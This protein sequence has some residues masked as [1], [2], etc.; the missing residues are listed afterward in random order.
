MQAIYLD[1]AATTPIHPDVLKV[2]VE[3]MEEHFGNPSSVHSYGRKARQ[4]LDKARMTAAKSIGASDK[5]IIFTSGGTEADN[6]ALIGVAEANKNKGNHIITTKIEHHA[7]LHAAEKLEKEGYHVTYLDVQENGTIDIEQLKASLTDDTILVSVMM[8]NNET[9][10]IQPIEAIGQLLEQHQAYFHT[11]AVQAY[12]LLPINVKELKVDLLTVSSHKINGP[13]GVGFL[14]VHPDVKMTAQQYGGEQ[15]RKR[16]PGTENVAGIAGFAKAIEIAAEKQQE[17]MQQYK[18]YRTLF[19]EQLE[20]SAIDFSINGTESERVANIV[21]IS[22][23]GANVEQLLTN[24]DL[25]GIAASSGSACTAGSVE[26]SHVLTAMFSENNPCTTNSIRF[27]FGLANNE[28]N[29]VTAA[30]KVGQIVQR[31]TK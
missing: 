9:G 1:H 22:F 12:G 26:P 10:V 18:H 20:K 19:L 3:T 2:V 15:E 23:P 5:D 31:L 13:K 21:N 11:D 17:R 16:R 25:S 24:F 30:E 28:E 4:I 29:V 8:V 14:Y 6:L 7:T 27:S